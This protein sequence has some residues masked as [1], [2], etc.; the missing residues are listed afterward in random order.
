MLIYIYIYITNDGLCIQEIIIAWLKILMMMLHM[1]TI[2]MKKNEDSKMMIKRLIKRA[3][4][5]LQNIN[6]LGSIK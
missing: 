6:R 5:L 4:R 3:C 2:C 1:K